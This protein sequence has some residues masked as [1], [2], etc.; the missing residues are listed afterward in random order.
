MI[1]RLL[2]Y[3]GLVRW[4]DYDEY[5]SSRRW[6]KLRLQCYRRDG[7]RCRI[8]N[9]SWN[10]NAHHRRYARRWG[11]ETVDDLTTLCSLCHTIFE[12]TGGLK[13]AEAF[14]GTRERLRA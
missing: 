8:C 11:E 9:S 14:W 2:L 1:R 7:F 10:L 12:D 5:R 4:R 13:A 6:R 3:L